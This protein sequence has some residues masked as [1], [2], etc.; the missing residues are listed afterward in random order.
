VVACLTILLV[1]LTGCQT[2]REVSN[3]RKVDFAIDRVSEP[4]LAGVNLRDVRSYSDLG[5]SDMLRLSAAIADREMPLSFTVHVNARNP[6]ANDVNARLTQM[7]W[8]LLLQER[9]TI[10]GT[11]NRET[12]LRP[13]EPTDLPI[14]LELNLVEFFGNNLRDIVNLAL[15]LRGEQAATNVKLQVRPTVRTPIGP[16][17]YPGTITVVDQNVGRGTEGQ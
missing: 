4:T 5:A 6:A 17:T 11:F 16:M 2:L 15:S 8:T 3:L 13:G 7:N 9:E 10:S 14:N 1:G 12:V